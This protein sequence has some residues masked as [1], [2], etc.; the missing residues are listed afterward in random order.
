MNG[1]VKGTKKKDNPDYEPFEKNGRTYYR[2]KRSGESSGMRRTSGGNSVAT[3]S[4]NDVL[5]DITPVQEEDV[6]H[7]LAEEKDDGTLSFSH[8]YGKERNHAIQNELIEG[9]QNLVIDEKEFA[10]HIDFVRSNYNYS[11]RNQLL[12]NLQKPDGTVFKTYK[13]WQALGYQVAR[14]KKQ[15]FA[16]R[17]YFKD[18]LD[19]N[20]NPVLDKNGKPA[21]VLSNYGHYGKIFSDKDLDSS[22]KEPPKN[23]LTHHFNRYMERDD[24]DDVAA[25]REDLTKVAE[26]M[27]IPVES[28]SRNDDPLLSS[29]AGGYAQRTPNGYRIVIS[30]DVQPHAATHVLSHEMAH[31]LCGHLDRGIYSPGEK[32]N[33]KT[34]SEREVEAETMAYAI[35]RDYGLDTDNF[36]FSYLHGW[37]DNDPKK[38]ENAMGNVSRGL[39]KYY[40]ELETIVT[41][42]NRGEIDSSANESNLKKSQERKKK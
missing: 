36:A 34:P 29:G 18:K 22:V 16:L 32:S 38:I 20:G 28:K 17:P 8:L 39:K 19:E 21:K 27:G 33:F 13:Q 3:G 24:I 30:D 23:P 41:G 1:I 11:F 25:M 4:I 31:I 37:A 7:I 6:S 35:S 15:A 26:K 14:G 5:G 42:T 2:K 12:L 10:N 9:M 40:T